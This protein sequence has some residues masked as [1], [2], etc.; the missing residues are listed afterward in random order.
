ML[1]QTVEGKSFISPEV[2]IRHWRRSAHDAPP[3]LRYSLDVAANKARRR[4][5]LSFGQYLALW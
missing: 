1:E 5:R 2:L 3:H 4:S